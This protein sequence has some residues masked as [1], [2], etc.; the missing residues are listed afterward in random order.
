MSFPFNIYFAA[1]AVAAISSAAAF[2]FWKRW[3]E[4]VGHFDGPGHR[5]IH[6]ER[7][8]LAGGMVVMTG[9]FLPLLLGGITVFFWEIPEMD[10]NTR[11]LIQYGFS[12]RAFQILAILGGAFAMVLLG[13]L[14][15]QYELPPGTKL[16]GQALVALLIAS[17]GIRITLFIP[18]GPVNYFVTILWIV[19]ITNALNFLDNMNGLCSGLGIIIA[20]TCAWSAAIQG[21]YLVSLLGFVIC[22]ALLGFFP[23][24]FP[25][26]KAFLG[27]AGSHLVGFL[28]AV[29]A[30]LPN[31]YS[32]ET[33]HVFAV[34]SPLLILAIPLFDLVSVIWIRYRAG[35]PV[36][37]GDMNH[38]SH[39]LVRRGFS[40]TQAVL[41]ILLVQ[42]IISA[43]AVLAL[44]R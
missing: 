36:Y 31:F 1:I 10:P 8:P 17:S 26:A 40:H 39:R 21:Q 7:V 29:L 3:C 11:G 18:V 19:S 43:L 25:R 13:W 42:S 14:D 27:D 37:L 28:A 12:R 34:L 41:L 6:S 38:I 35:K 5:K 16:G 33:P 2:P 24:N 22:G 9:F 20:W 15:D 23:F 30:I 44:M 32:R 4:S